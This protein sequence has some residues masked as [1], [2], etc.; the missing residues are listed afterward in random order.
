MNQQITIKTLDCLSLEKLK[1]D[2]FIPKGSI[3]FIPANTEWHSTNPSNK[4]GIT[5]KDILIRDCK[6]CQ[7]YTT[8]FT[9]AGSGGYWKWTE[10]TNCLI[11]PREKQ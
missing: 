7:T 3:I 6:E 9:W 4:S 1:E 11:V 5:K 10:K 8:H 2:S